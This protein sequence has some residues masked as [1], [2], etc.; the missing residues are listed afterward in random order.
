[1]LG[2]VIPDRRRQIG[3]RLI[4]HGPSLPFVQVVQYL[5]GAPVTFDANQKQL[6]RLRLPRFFFY[7]SL[8]RGETSRRS[9]VLD[10]LSRIHGLK[11]RCAAALHVWPP[12]GEC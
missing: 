4:R 8:A 11:T 6:L 1:M 12:P 7:P 9:G 3:V 5:A 10:F 2:Q